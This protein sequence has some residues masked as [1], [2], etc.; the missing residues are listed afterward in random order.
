MSGFQERMHPSFNPG[1]ESVT[2][3]YTEASRNPEKQAKLT[4]AK[5]KGRAEA[6][7]HNQSSVRRRL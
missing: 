7:G 4:N 1:P 3:N 5:Y 2:E 6:V